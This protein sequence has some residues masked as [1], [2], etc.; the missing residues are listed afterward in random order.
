MGSY[1]S[2]ND[3]YACNSQTCTLS[4][5]SPDFGA[6]VCYSMQQN[7]LDGTTCGGG[8]RCENGVCKGSSVGGEVKSWIDDNKTLVIALASA[9]GGLLLLAI[10]GCCIRACRRPRG[11]RMPVVAGGHR[12]RRGVHGNAPRGGGWNGPQIPEEMRD[13]GYGGGGW[14]QPPPEMTAPQAWYPPPQQP[15]PAYGTGGYNGYPQHGQSV[16]YA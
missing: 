4:C 13:R 10:L 3:T 1:T 16:R 8:G 5:A 12:H 7:F 9:I 2:D 11:K 14:Q 15:P 6:N